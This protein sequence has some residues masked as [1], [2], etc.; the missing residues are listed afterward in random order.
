MAVRV[1]FT[2][3]CLAGV[4]IARAAPVSL[5]IEATVG[6]QQLGLTRAPGT[7][8]PLLPMGDAGATVLLRLGPVALGAAAEGN[9]E[10]STLERF[11]ASA[12]GGLVTDLLPVLRLELLG[13]VGSANLRSSSDL[14]DAAGGDERWE[15]FYGFRP[16]LSARLPVLPVRLGVWGLARWGMPGSD[17][18]PQLGLL[19]RLGV[20]F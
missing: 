1:L 6:A 5:G 10:G 11:N 20:E 12:M 17:G 15:R 4:S 2:L 19:G 3:A 14:R 13:E 8:E 16:G 9:F 18:G 7:S